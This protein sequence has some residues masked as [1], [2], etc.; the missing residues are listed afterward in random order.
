MGHRQVQRWNLPDGWIIPAHL[1]HL[2]LVSES[3]FIAAQSVKVARG[4]VSGNG[5]AG[6]G[7][8]QYLLSGLLTCGTCGRRMEP[9]WSNGKAAYRCRHGHTSAFG[10]DRDRPKNAY[11]REDRILSH[12]PALQLLAQP[13]RLTARRRR[14][15][16]GI[17]VR[18]AISPRAVVEFLLKNKIGLTYDQAEGTLTLPVD[19][20][21]IAKTIIRKSS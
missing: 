9:T 19:T 5:L 7:R 3:D 12:L 20:G 4:P 14:T 10:R 16:R 6:Q 18:S 21:V 15:R 1:A 11:I 17:D 13:E 2:P 8:R